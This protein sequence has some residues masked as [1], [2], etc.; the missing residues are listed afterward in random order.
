MKN[1]IKWLWLSKE[2]MKSVWSKSWSYVELKLRNCIFIGR[3]LFNMTKDFWK[4]EKE[5]SK[6]IDELLIQKFPKK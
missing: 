6:K 2:F 3:E 5:V 1:R 4:T